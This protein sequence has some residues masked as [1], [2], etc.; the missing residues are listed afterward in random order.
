MNGNSYTCKY[1]EKYL[2]LQQYHNKDEQ[3]E[4]G[5]ILKANKN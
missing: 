2:P 3:V 5:S 1:T 4:E